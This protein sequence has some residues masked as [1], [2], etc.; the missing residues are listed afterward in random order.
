MNNTNQ[1]QLE[2]E[3]ELRCL[4]SHYMNFVIDFGYLN[5]EDPDGKTETCYK[6]RKDKRI[7]FLFFCSNFLLASKMCFW[8]AS[9]KL[10]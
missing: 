5:A 2:V 4:Y 10:T 7:F 8:I 3:D 6:N 1:H 9:L